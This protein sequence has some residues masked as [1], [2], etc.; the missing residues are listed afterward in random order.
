MEKEIVVNAGFGETRAAIREDRRLVDLFLERENHQLVVG[1][2]YKGRVE[3]VLPGMQAA[4]VNIGLERN[5]FLYVDDALEHRNGT[6]GGV[7]RSRVKSIKDVLKEGDEVIV[8]VAKG[9]IGTKGARIVTNLS[10]PGRYVVLMPTMDHIAVSRRITNEAER[11]RLK[12]IAKKVCP[13]GTG[14]IIR[15]LAQGK[16]EHAIA[17]DCRFLLSV[18]K[19]IQRRAQSLPAPSLLYKDFDLVYRLVRDD[20]TPEVTKFIVD[21]DS[22]YRSI[23][24]LLDSFS[25]TMKSRVYKYSG[26]K[27]IFEFYGIEEQINRSLQRK[28][29]LESGGYIVIDHTEALTSID[30]N[31]GRF[32]GT[33]NLADTVLKTNLEAAREIAYQLRLR[34]IG[35]IIIIDFID[36]DSDSHRRQVLEEFEAALGRDKTRSHIL[37][38]TN[39]GLLEMTRKKVGEDMITRLQRTCM[40]CEGSGRVL[41]EETVAHRAQRELIKQARASEDEAFLVV[42]HPSV[43][44]LM[45]GPNGSVLHRLEQQTKKTLYVKGADVLH[46]E[47]FEIISGDKRSVE[48]QAFPVRPGEVVDIHIEEPH[49]TNPNDGIARIE[50]YVI[51]VEGGG[52]HIGQRHKVEITRVFRTYAKA[53]LVAN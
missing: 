34:D 41:S 8:Q 27:P 30:V 32:I 7:G 11:E 33:T 52:R 53:K 15:T 48:E 45:I 39:L 4:F 14:L 24:E 26:T 50:G 13:K 16:D 46:V 23:L 29:W 31:T 18:C 35:G 17:Q 9:P 38:F 1:N 2:I 51:D 42:C 44:A 5:A 6:D 12:A 49:I 36:M 40:Y 37:G 19:K 21:D 3:N 47:E 28:V 25:P 20:F 43:A 10:I 22:V